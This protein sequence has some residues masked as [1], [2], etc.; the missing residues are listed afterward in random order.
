MIDIAIVIVS[1]FIGAVLCF[2]LFHLYELKEKVD[3]HIEEQQH[4][5]SATKGVLI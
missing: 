3:K 2:I 5:D 1:V 4:S